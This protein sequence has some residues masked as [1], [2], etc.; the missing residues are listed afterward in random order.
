MYSDN[1]FSRIVNYNTLFGGGGD[2]QTRLFLVDFFL[3]FKLQQSKANGRQFKI[4]D[5]TNF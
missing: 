5:K 3:Y 4:T 1:H 2:F